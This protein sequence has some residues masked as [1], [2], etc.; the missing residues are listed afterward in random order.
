MLLT[1]RIES[2]WSILR[3]QK[4][5][6]WIDTFKVTM[7]IPLKM[8]VSSFVTNGIWNRMGTLIQRVTLTSMKYTQQATY[9]DT[10]CI[11]T[12]PVSSHCIPA[13]TWGRVARV[14][15]LLEL[16]PTSSK[17]GCWMSSRNSGWSIRYARALW[18]GELPQAC[19]SKFVDGC[20][21]EWC[22]P[23]TSYVQWRHLLWL[24]WASLSSIWYW[25]P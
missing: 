18:W 21:A 16:T 25:S 15:A 11:L 20:H 5:G 23:S 17:L 1:Q 8:A 7:T 13:T 19:W 14:C 12:Q 22:S 24:S 6:W 10:L 2:W 3:R 9:S 4:T